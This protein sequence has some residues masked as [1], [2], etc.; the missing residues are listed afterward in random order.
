MLMP[1]EVS[2]NVFTKLEFTTLM[3]PAF[4]A[5]SP[6]LAPIVSSSPTEPTQPP[7]PAVL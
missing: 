7:P 2:P 4:I 1:G 5:P 6:F 3:F